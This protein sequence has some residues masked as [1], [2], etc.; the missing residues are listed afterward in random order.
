MTGYRPVIGG[1]RHRTRLD[2]R[3]PDR[4]SLKTLC[5]MRWQAHRGPRSPAVGDCEACEE[6]AE[7]TVDGSAR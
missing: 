1:L 4:T 7:T 3:P 6:I 5:E 2:E